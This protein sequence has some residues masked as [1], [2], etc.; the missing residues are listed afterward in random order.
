MRCETRRLGDRQIV[1][2]LEDDRLAQA[3]LDFVGR[4]DG[5]ALLRHAHRRD[6]DVVAQRQLPV[7]LGPAT[8]DPDLPGAQQPVDVR[9]RHAPQLADQEIVDSLARFPL[10]DL[11]MAHRAA[12][13]WQNSD[14]P[15]KVMPGETLTADARRK[16]SGARSK[17]NSSRPQES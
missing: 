10:A 14:T 11:D 16:S 1:G 9:L 6:A 8:V 7:R 2:V 12:L 3:V 17:D 4:P 15:E 13:F 5:L